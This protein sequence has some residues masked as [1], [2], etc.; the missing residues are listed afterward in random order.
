MSY[1]V[2]V[3]RPFSIM[4]RRKKRGG[5]EKGKPLGMEWNGDGDLLLASHIAS[6]LAKPASPPPLMPQPS[7]DG[8][9]FCLDLGSSNK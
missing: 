6:G 7:R 8:L 2:R 5:G 3:V 4:P 9:L 1:V